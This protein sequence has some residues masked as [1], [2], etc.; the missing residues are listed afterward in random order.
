MKK[1]IKIAA[2]SLA[3][4]ATL[5]ACSQQGMTSAEFRA[6]L[7]RDRKIAFDRE[8]DE[9]YWARGRAEIEEMMENRR[10]MCEGHSSLRPKPNCP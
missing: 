5:G 8:R 10:A 1:P 6:E 3:L 4:L 7:D 2:V 9:A